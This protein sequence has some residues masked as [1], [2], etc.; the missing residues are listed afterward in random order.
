MRI[1]RNLQ[2]LKIR[3]M[4]LDVTFIDELAAHNVLLNKLLRTTAGLAIRETA[5]QGGHGQPRP[6]NCSASPRRHVEPLD[7]VPF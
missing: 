1:V 3:S 7:E 6:A 2:S 5:P 4:H